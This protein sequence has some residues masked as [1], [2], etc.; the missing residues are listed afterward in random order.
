MA[1]IG[2]TRLNVILW[3]TL[4]YFFDQTLLTLLQFFQIIG[5]FTFMG[6]TNA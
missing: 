3:Q 6:Y 1:R 2:R 4:G 5:L